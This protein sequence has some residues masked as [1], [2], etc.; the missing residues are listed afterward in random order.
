MTHEAYLIF[1]LL[2]ALAPFK[3]GAADF[4]PL[5]TMA[6]IKALLRT[7]S[8]QDFTKDA[9]CFVSAESSYGLGVVENCIKEFKTSQGT[10]WLMRQ[11]I[12]TTTTSGRNIA[13]LIATYVEA[14][15]NQTPISYYLELDR[16]A[17]EARGTIVPMDY[18]VPCG[19]CH[20]SGPR[21]IRPQAASEKKFSLKDKRLLTAFNKRI[22]EYKIVETFKP[23]GTT[24]EK[25]YP[26]QDT[27]PKPLQLAAC[28]ECHNSKTG[29]RAELSTHQAASIHYLAFASGTDLGTAQMPT[30]D[31]PALNAHDTGC[32]KGWLA[33]TESADCSPVV[34]PSLK[35]ETSWLTAKVET[36]LHSFTITGLKVTGTGVSFSID[37]TT[38]KSGI[39]ARDAHIRKL[40]NTAAYP[41]ITGTLGMIP[42]GRS[43][44]VSPVLLQIG[45]QKQ[46]V[47]VAF[48]CNDVHSQC[49]LA[50]TVDLSSFHLIMPRFLGISVNPTIHIQ[51]QIIL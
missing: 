29:V 26:R 3:A 23:S 8:A 34:L 37:L 47:D 19:M 35:K 45:D 12:E 38:L 50:S 9:L 4:V 49:N 32:L 2:S 36:S 33:G 22:L 40:F 30:L 41:A 21:L 24:G 42:K 11:N 17:F 5:K 44:F 27:P 31:A 25:L 20:S 14:R 51:G 46:T 7:D 13:N 48:D 43:A 16:P 1:T 6:T 39:S 10:L 15:P 18:K 28:Y